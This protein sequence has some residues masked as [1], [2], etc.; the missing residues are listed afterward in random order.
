MTDDE[1]V[2]RSTPLKYKRS[3]EIGLRAV[4]VLPIQVHYVSLGSVSKVGVFVNALHFSSIHS[5]C[6]VLE[7]FFNDANFF[8]KF[9]KLFTSLT[10]TGQAK[11][12]KGQ[13]GNQAKHF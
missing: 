4:E 8:C 1:A 13:Q 6:Q 12:A 2:V 10:G 5:L 11:K 9:N 3:Y 7:T